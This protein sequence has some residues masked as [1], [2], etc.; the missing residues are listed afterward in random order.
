MTRPSATTRATVLVA[1]D[2]EGCAVVAAERG[3]AAL[4]L[5]RRYR[6]DAALI[7]VA[8]AGLS[9]YELCHR[10]R[11][12][13][14]ESISIILI[15]GVRTEGLDR[16]AGLLL[17]ADDYVVKPFEPNELMARVRRLLERAHRPPE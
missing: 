5:A 12:E 7:D 1:D 14:G 16:I 6:P 9:G 10:L 13:F 17:G 15:S 3:D 4:Q 2:A 11:E 8:M